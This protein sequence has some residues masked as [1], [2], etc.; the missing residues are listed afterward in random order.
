MKKSNPILNFMQRED[1]VT[2]KVNNFINT[3]ITDLID[4]IKHITIFKVSII[5][6]VS[7]VQVLMIKS[8]FGNKKIDFNLSNP[9][10][11]SKI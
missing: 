3:V 10:S 2:I 5:I 6:L 7:L 11:D 8:F 9:F 4:I 1:R